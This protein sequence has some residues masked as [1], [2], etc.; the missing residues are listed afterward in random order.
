MELVFVDVSSC[1]TLSEHHRRIQIIQFSLIPFPFNNPPSPQF[2]SEIVSSKISL[3]LSPRY[4]YLPEK[5]IKAVF[6]TSID[7]SLINNIWDFSSMSVCLEGLR[8]A[9]YV[10][11]KELRSNSWHP[12]REKLNGSDHIGETVL[13]GKIKIELQCVQS[14]N[15]DYLLFA[16]EMVQ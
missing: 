5:R 1:L 8:L 12:L 2:N 13:G 11:R 4:Y 14:K 6:T 15:L 7:S 10:V 3:Q 16:P 9:G